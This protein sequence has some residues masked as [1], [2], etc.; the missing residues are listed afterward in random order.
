MVPQIKQVVAEY[1]Q[2]VL[3]IPFVPPFSYKRGLLRDDSGPNRLFF[4]F[5]FCD[6]ALGSHITPQT[7][8]RYGLG[9]V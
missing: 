4:T 5:L 2:H 7:E 3:N 1:V 6:K 9:R 8:L